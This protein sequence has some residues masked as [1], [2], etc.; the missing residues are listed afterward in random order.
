MSDSQNIL[1][2]R[3][4][5][6]FIQWSSGGRKAFM[7][8]SHRYF[9]II[10][11]N[12][13]SKGILDSIIIKWV[14][15]FREWNIF[16]RKR[17]QMWSKLASRA[18]IQRAWSHKILSHSYSTYMKYLLGI[19]PRYGFLPNHK[20]DEAYYIKISYVNVFMKS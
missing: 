8:H 19:R 9:D 5:V 16:R 6:D 1:S 15:L 13:L 3:A 18:I 10:I 14:P 12:M 11:L 2:K 7:S 20:L 4:W 17:S